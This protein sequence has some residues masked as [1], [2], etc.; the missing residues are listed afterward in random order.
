MAVPESALSRDRYWYIRAIL[1]PFVGG[2]VG[3]FL[4]WTIVGAIVRGADPFASIG[5]FLLSGVVGSVVVGMIAGRV[6]AHGARLLGLIVGLVGVCATI[7][8][9]WGLTA[10]AD[11]YGSLLGAS[12]VVWALFASGY[13]IGAWAAARA[14]SHAPADQLCGRCGQHLRPYWTEACQYC[15]ALFSE[16]PPVPDQAAVAPP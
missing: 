4:L 15:D 3:T 6:S 14:T 10:N 8:V 1:P 12:F 7:T 5:A 16:F 2:A 11:T 13:G 9:L